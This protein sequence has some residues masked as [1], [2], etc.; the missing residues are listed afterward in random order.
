MTHLASWMDAYIRAWHT[1]DPDD[2]GALFAD[3]AVYFTEPYA[4]PWR[5][6]DAIVTRW[7]ERKDTDGPAAFEYEPVAVTEEV[8]VV[9]GVT[10]YPDTAFSNLWLVRLDAGGR[11]TEF[12]EYWMEQ[13]A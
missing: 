6:K 1:N 8:A 9:K 13:P 7:L 3:D 4:E 5:G 10:T 11:C 12:V 2:I